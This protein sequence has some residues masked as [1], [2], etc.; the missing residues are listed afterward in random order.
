LQDGQKVVVRTPHGARPRGN[1]RTFFGSAPVQAVAAR[2]DRL[3]EDAAVHGGGLSS[4]TGIAG[5]F[6]FLGLSRKISDSGLG[7]CPKRSHEEQAQPNARTANEDAATEKESRAKRLQFFCDTHHVSL[8]NPKSKCARRLAEC[9]D[10]LAPNGNFHSVKAKSSIIKTHPVTVSV[11][12]LHDL[13]LCQ[14][15]FVFESI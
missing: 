5:L 2:A 11:V 4:L 8:Q 3:K 6:W 13:C 7:T 15:L 12:L 10:R 14:L 9:A 1:V